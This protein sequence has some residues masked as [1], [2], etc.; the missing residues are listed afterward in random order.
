[1]GGYEVHIELSSDP[2]KALSK[3]P[4]TKNA[5]WGAETDGIAIHCKDEGRSFVFLKHNASAGNVAHESWHVVRRMMNWLGV[6][7]DNEAVA[8]HLGY[9][10]NRIVEA[11]RR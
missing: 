8:Y 7:L 5:E 11:Q 6:D 10:V 1:M 3:Y 2:E 4:E 9:L